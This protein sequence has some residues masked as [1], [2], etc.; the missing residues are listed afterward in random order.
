M[1]NNRKARRA[2]AKEDLIQFIG[3][4]T[5][6]A[7]YASRDGITWEIVKPNTFFHIDKSLRIPGPFDDQLG[8]YVLNKNKENYKFTR[9]MRT[10]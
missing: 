1:K 6:R 5:S 4:N 3:A 7:L 9:M 2:K 8:R 10:I